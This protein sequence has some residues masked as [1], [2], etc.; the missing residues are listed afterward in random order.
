M[1][2]MKLSAVLLSIGLVS[3]CSNVPNGHVGV[4]IDRYGDD[5]GVQAETF[6]P[7]RYYIGPTAD[8]YLFPTFSQNDAWTKEANEFSPTDESFAFQ[9]VE[10][11]S[12]GAD[13]GFSYHIKPEDAPRVF[14]KYRRTVQEISSVVLRNMTRDA[15]NQVASGMLIE[16]IYGKGKVDLQAKVFTIVQKEAAKSGITVENLFFIGEIRLP[17]A[18]RNSINAKIA[19]TQEAI[20]KENE[21][22]SAI[23]DAE[24]AIAEARGQAESTEILGRAL[25][26]NPAVLKHKWLEKWN[27]K[28]PTTVAGDSSDIIISLK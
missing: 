5:R 18:V 12:V 10:G 6:K 8:M 27:G 21:L 20:R 2:I 22:R 7:G 14:E 1:K 24:K 28:L 15:L 23:A 9:S 19:A 3:A 26:Q 13:I 16:D 11:L 17:A 25:A 4:K